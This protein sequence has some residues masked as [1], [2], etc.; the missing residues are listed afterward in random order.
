MELRDQTMIYV[1]NMNTIDRLWYR[2][3]VDKD[4]DLE[5]LEYRYKYR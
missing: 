2:C 4:I 5:R 1:K 3:D